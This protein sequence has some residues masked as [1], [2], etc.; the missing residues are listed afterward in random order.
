[1]NIDIKEAIVNSI[2]GKSKLSDEVLGLE[3]LSSKLVRH[4]LNNIASTAKNYLEVGVYLGST[5]ISANYNNN[6]IIPIYAVDNFTGFFHQDKNNKQKLKNNL[7][8]FLDNYNYKLIDKS[9]Q[10]LTFDDIP[11]NYIELYLYD[12]DHDYKSQ[13]DG[14]VMMDKFL[15]N[16]FV[17]MVDDWNYTDV[18][19]GTRDALSFM[20]NYTVIE[21]YILPASFTGDTN[22]YWNGL[23]VARIIKK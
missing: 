23:F 8:L 9:F 19:N 1:M 15:A 22:M 17:L 12:G 13:Y 16:E 4:F 3:G 5:F 7:E 6:K 18:Q 10:N 2:I 14:I 21:E 11:K 20:T